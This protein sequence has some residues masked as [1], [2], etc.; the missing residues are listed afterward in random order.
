MGFPVSAAFDRVSSIDSL[1]WIS[2]DAADANIV[3]T[4]KSKAPNEMRRETEL[5]MVFSLF[6]F[7]K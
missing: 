4:I 6:V 7:R 5:N 2:A 3:P 1:H